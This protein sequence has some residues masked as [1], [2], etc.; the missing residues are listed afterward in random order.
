MDTENIALVSRNL[1]YSPYYDELVLLDGNHTIKVERWRIDFY[2]DFLEEVLPPI[3]R[4]S[5]GCAESIISMLKLPYFWIYFTP[6]ERSRVESEI[7]DS[8]DFGQYLNKPSHPAIYVYDTTLEDGSYRFIKFNVEENRLVDAIRRALDFMDSR[9]TQDAVEYC[10]SQDAATT[11]PQSIQDLQAQVDTLQRQLE[12][13]RDKLME[14]GLTSADVQDVLSQ[15]TQIKKLYIDRHNKIFLQ[16]ADGTIGAEIR[17]TPLDKA[18]YM[19]FLNH[20]EGINFSYLPD[21]RN[22]LL[23]IYHTLMN[24]RT[25]RD[26]EQSVIDVTDPTGNSINEKCAH[27]RRTFTAHLGQYKA[28]EYIIT[29]PRGERKCI[30]LD[31]RFV[32]VE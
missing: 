31:R 2:K 13:C 3:E 29:G 23:Q 4:V 6:Q 20:P 32:V 14:L 7:I 5:D 28:A 25:S 17:M 26:M 27:I 11:Q 15:D 9:D 30:R 12:L 19:L 18:V 16:D 1:P 21:Y 8:L 22:E 10:K 24:C